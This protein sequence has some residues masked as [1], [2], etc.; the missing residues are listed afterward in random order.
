VP[1]NNILVVTPDLHLLLAPIGSSAAM[2][3]SLE[4]IMSMQR[5]MHEEV[6][7]RGQR[8]NWMW[9]WVYYKHT[10]ALSLLNWI[11][12]VASKD[13]SNPGRLT[14]SDSMFSP[15]DNQQIIPAYQGPVCVQEMGLT[16]HSD[17]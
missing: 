17:V 2:S 16:H 5:Y 3:L 11:F 6:R 13:S 15:V 14:P 7:R 1:K 4:N 9:Y 10:W 8:E 12:V